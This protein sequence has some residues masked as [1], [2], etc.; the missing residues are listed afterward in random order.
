MIRPLLPRLTGF[1]IWAGAFGVLYG[2]QALGCVWHWPEALHR[3]S[4]I[5]LWLIALVVLGALSWAQWKHVGRQREQKQRRY[6]FL[7]TLAATAATLVTFF[8][9]TFAT[10]CQ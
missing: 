9:V 8:P 4:L 2:V 7:V 1:T 6:D 5:I 3:G 10:L